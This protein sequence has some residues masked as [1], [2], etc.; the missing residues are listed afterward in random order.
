MYITEPCLSP[1]ICLTLI[2]KIKNIILITKSRISAIIASTEWNNVSLTKNISAVRMKNNA[3]T[4][5]DRISRI[6]TDTSAVFEAL[7]W[8]KYTQ[9]QDARMLQKANDDT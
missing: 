3:K 7:K 1:E 5:Y 6:L 4:E 8:P 9:H 2:M